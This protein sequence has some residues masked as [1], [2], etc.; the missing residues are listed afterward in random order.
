MGH[1]R[2]KTCAMVMSHAT[3]FTVLRQ[4]SWFANREFV[5]CLV[6]RPIARAMFAH[7]EKSAP[8][9]PHDH[10]INHPCENVGSTLSVAIWQRSASL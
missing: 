8:L 2:A 9:S 6:K 4:E 5:D 1:A 10:D 7:E 3:I